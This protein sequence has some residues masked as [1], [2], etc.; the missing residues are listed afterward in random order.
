MTTVDRRRLVIE[1]QQHTIGE[2]TYVFL[3][4]VHLLDGV[5]VMRIVLQ[6]AH[7]VQTLRDDRRDVHIL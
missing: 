6:L 4:A 7:C 2:Q 1:T 5:P 3:G